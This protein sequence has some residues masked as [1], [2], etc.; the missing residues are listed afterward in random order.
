MAATT[1]T[2]K[3]NAR[4]ASLE[5]GP[6]HLTVLV[7]RHEAAYGL[8]AEEGSKFPGLGAAVAGAVAI[9][10][11]VGGEADDEAAAV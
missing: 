5:D 4:N 7:R 2:K 11:V 3:K 10:S 8:V 9:G 1:T 6:G